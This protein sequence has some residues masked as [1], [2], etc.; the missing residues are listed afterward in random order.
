LDTLRVTHRECRT[1]EEVERELNSRT[2]NDLI[3]NITLAYK[4]TPPPQPF[5]HQALNMKFISSRLGTYNWQ[6]CSEMTLDSCLLT[7]LI[8]PLTTFTTLAIDG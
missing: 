1:P 5:A 2:Y 7:F 3:A 4:D 6:D 8:F